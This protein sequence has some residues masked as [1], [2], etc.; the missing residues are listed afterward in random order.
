[1]AKTLLSYRDQAPEIW[2]RMRS[3]P[4]LREMSW[5]ERRQVMTAEFDALR[6][7][8]VK[9]LEKII[10]PAD[11]KSLAEDSMRDRGGRMG[12][13]PRSTNRSRNR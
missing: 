9:E 1:V 6:E 11:A 10:P 2:R 4:E 3:D 13:R 5:E 7:S 8:A 12:T